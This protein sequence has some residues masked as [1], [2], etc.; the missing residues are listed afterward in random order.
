MGGTSFADYVWKPVV[1]IEMKKRGTDLSRHYRQAF[2]Y[3][4]RLVP[5]RPQYVVLC[6]FDEFRVY[7]FNTQLD[8]PKVTVQLVDLPDRYGPL[9]FLFPPNEKPQFN[10]DREAI[11]RHRAKALSV[12]EVFIAGAASRATK[13]AALLETTKACFAPQRSRNLKK[14]SDPSPSVQMYE[15]IRNMSGGKDGSKDD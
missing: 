9:A 2:D 8:E 13:D 7:D 5:G 14:D 10:N 4:T 11:N 1:L 6:N 12:F 3:W 15:I